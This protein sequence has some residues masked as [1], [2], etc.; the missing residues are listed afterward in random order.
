MTNQGNGSDVA[1]LA[2]ELR[3]TVA[4]KRGWFTALGI[5]LVHR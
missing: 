5:L 2:N 3:H 4:E 1:N